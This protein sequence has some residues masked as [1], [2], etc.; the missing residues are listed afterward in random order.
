MLSSLLA[1]L[2][3]SAKPCVLKE[4]ESMA[5]SDV[6]CRMQ[7]IG[8][9]LENL[10]GHTAIFLQN[11]NDYTAALFAGMAYGTVV[12]PLATTLT[13]HEVTPLLTSADIATVITSHVF[14]DLF[15][16]IKAESLPGIIIIYIEDAVLNDK[17]NLPVPVTINPKAPL[18]MLPT[19]GTTGNAKIV[20]LS[21]E[22]ILTSA[23]GFI[24]KMQ[25]SLFEDLNS[26]FIIATP[27][28]SSY[29]I[30]VIIACL[31]KGFPLIPLPINFTLNSFFKTAELHSATHYE[32]GAHTLL[33]M[34][35]MA[36]R[37]IPYDISSLKCFGVGGSKISG[38]TITALL[39]AY[40]GIEISQGYGMT[41]TSPLCA[42]NKR[43]NLT[44]PNSVGT[45]I[46]GVQL[47]VECDG[48]IT[49]KPFAK[50]EILVKGPNVMLGYY[51]N[52]AATAEVVK[53]GYMH[54]GD[55]GYIDETGHLYI[56]GRKKNII[57]VGGLNVHPEEV[58]E[59]LL[60]SGLVK[61][62]CVYGRSHEQEE[63]LCADIV[64]MH[65]QVKKEDIIL[66][67]ATHLAKHKQPK[68]MKLCQ[69]IEK[70]QNGKTVRRKR[71]LNET[72]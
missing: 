58:E 45:A 63:I 37:K 31:I 50:G 38:S 48:Q 25:F 9:K 49:A 22:N 40:P 66:Y 54:T 27:F 14:S 11:L 68:N 70:N 72:T 2:E 21:E 5:F 62:C 67:C 30:M 8:Q 56:I 12:F 57:I 19:S 13:I 34:E 61:D 7:A 28:T 52:P 60:Q 44:Q 71:G 32:G 33:L 18:L 24:E 3:F 59:C 10:N 6:F 15:E 1:S 47:A 51:K 64:P 65:P 35:Q 20:Q 23:N 55:I 43:P 53:N 4:N 46:E 36:G 41:E 17:T 16:K 69:N 26:K 42:K 29:G 39:K